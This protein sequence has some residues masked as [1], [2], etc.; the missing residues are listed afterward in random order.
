LKGVVLVVVCGLAALGACR[1]ARVPAADGS[2][3]TSACDEYHQK[4]MRCLESDRWPAQTRR[5]A[6]AS[7]ERLRETERAATIPEA[8]EMRE[9]GCRT[10]LRMMQQ[11]SQWI[12]PG[13]W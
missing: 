2:I 12:C 11:G 6:R 3:T 7:I 8:R 9:S 5:E 4:M 13:V 10:T 1:R